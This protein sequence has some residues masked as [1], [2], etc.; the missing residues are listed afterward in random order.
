VPRLQRGDPV[1]DRVELPGLP[2]EH[3][4]VAA[5]ARGGT[6][7]GGDLALVEVVGADGDDD[8]IGCGDRATGAGV[9]AG[10]VG[11]ETPLPGSAGLD[12]TGAG[13]DGLRGAAEGVSVGGWIRRASATAVPVPAATVST[14]AAASVAMPRRDGR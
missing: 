9:V 3:R 2:G 5:Q 8:Q 10:V 7:V 11:P 4:L 14:A 13:D 12:V 6:A 1:E